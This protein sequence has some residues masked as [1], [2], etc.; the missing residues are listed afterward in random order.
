[1]VFKQA[2]FIFFL[3]RHHSLVVEGNRFK[4]TIGSNFRVED[5]NNVFFQNA[6][7]HPPHCKCNKPDAHNM[8]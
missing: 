5:G 3:L 2:K 8:I 6:G 1:V 7:T 4:G